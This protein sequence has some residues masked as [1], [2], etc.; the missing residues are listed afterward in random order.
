MLSRCVYI[1]YSL[2]LDGNDSTPGLNVDYQ[3]RAHLMTSAH[4]S[5]SIGRRDGHVCESR[6]QS[7]MGNSMSINNHLTALIRLYSDNK[8]AIVETYALSM[9]DVFWLL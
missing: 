7:H 4:D 5:T 6:V 3:I 9:A 1:P 8:R 2:S